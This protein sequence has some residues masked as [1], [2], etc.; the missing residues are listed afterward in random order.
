MYCKHCG[1]KIADDSKFCNYCGA[2]QNAVS[3]IIDSRKRIDNS[4]IKK[5]IIKIIKIFV[6]VIIVGL[7]CAVI[8]QNRSTIEDFLGISNSQQ[9]ESET[10]NA[11]DTYKNTVVE[12]K[13]VATM[14]VKAGVFRLVNGYYKNTNRKEEILINVYSDGGYFLSDVLDDS[15]LDFGRFNYVMGARISP[16]QGYEYEI[17]CVEKGGNKIVYAFNIDEM[18]KVKEKTME[19]K[20]DY[21]KKIYQK[22]K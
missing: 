21:F 5:L 4:R 11:N 15:P 18:E 13:I 17:W 20:L 16:I 3:N 12:S 9:E 22:Q 10:I 7:V 14:K 8:V 2:N 19:E 1:K 6:I